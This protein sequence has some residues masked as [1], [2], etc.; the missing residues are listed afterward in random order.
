MSININFSYTKR[1]RFGNNKMIFDSEHDYTPNFKLSTFLLSGI[2]E[3]LEELIKIDKDSYILGIEY[4]HHDT[5]IAIT[6]TEQKYE[7]SKNALVRELEEEVGITT[8]SSNFT[9]EIIKKNET[10]TIKSY[11]LHAT[12]AM[13]YIEHEYDNFDIIKQ[14]VK[15]KKVQVIVWGTFEELDKL[16]KTIKKRRQSNETTSIIA[17]NIVRT[18]DVYEAVINN[19][20]LRGKI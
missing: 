15:S 9:H 12:Y 18:F 4:T 19:E 14:D 13:E 3:I 16:T 5:Q 10:K 2:C 8:H 11:L 17:I 1:Y 6:G 20:C 7:N